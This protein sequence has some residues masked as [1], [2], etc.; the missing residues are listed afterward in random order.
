MLLISIHAS[1]QWSKIYGGNQGPTLRGVSFLNGKTGY[2]V[3]GVEIAPTSCTVIKTIDG[4]ANWVTQTTPLDSGLRAIHCMDELTCVACGYS[5]RIIKTTDGGDNWEVKPSGTGETLRAIDFVSSTMGFIGVGFGYVL[6]TIDGSET[7]TLISTGVAEDIIQIEFATPAIGYCVSSTAVFSNGTVLKTTDGGDSWIPVY[8][9]ILQGLLALSV[10]DENLIYAGG[11]NR[12]PNTG[13]YPYIIKS[14]DGGDNWT[15]VYAGDSLRT[16][17]GADFISPEEGW[18]IGDLGYLLH[19]NDGGASWT[20]DSIWNQGNFGIHFP[21][22]DTG[23]VAGGASTILQYLNPC[24]SLSEIEEIFGPETV[25]S[26][27]TT[28][29]S[30]DT[31]FGANS[32]AWSVPSGSTIIQGDGTNE[33]VIVWGSSPGN[34]A[35]TAQKDCD[36][37]D[38]MALAVIVNPAPPVPNIT[39][40]NGIL[41]SDSQT[42]NQWYLNGSPIIDATD[43]MY[44]P[45]EN[46]I[47]WVVVTND[48]GCTSVSDPI[49]VVGVGLTESSDQG[50]FS[51]FPNPA[52]QFAVIQIQQPFHDLLI[53]DIHG[54]VIQEWKNGVPGDIQLDTSQWPRGVYFISVIDTHE[55]IIRGKLIIQ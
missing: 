23:Y 22:A 30:V 4:G 28:N 35:V 19:T 15:E 10:V 17:R 50:Y 41:T 55:I 53:T 48:L 24:P 45:I 14:T 13:G 3:G 9:N 11:G 39:F 12:T 42:G 44:T 52:N 27:D 6:K 25:C 43:S 21:N 40:D 51:I 47:Y 38:A 36:T 31:I 46:G 1:A 37:T 7:W 54:R 16:F 20:N 5:G 49:N 29:Y 2:I 34:V 33:I 8:S 32:Y 26:G 18:F